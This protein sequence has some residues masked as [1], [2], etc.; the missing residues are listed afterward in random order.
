VPWF[1]IATVQLN[2]KRYKDAYSS[3][4]KALKLN[5]Y[6]NDVLSLIKK[7]SN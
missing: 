3:S 6:D 7:L 5:P 2:L 1:L 4:Q